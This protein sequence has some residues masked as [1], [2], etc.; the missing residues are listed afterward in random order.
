V[1]RSDGPAAAVDGVVEREL[2][3]LD[4]A[5]RRDPARVSA[6]LHPEFT[7]FGASGRVWDR[8]SI[9]EVSSG[10]DEQIIATDMTGRWLGPD[11]V[12]LT[13]RSHTC[14]RQALR[15]SIWRRHEGEWLL[16]FHQG[17]PVG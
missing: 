1:P 2:A 14:G 16:L 3:L 17:T 12:L 5:V 6:F 9:G 8:G 7:E 4:P 13:Y 10:I 15:S 11:A